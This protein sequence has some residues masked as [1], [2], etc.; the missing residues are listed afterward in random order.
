MIVDKIET[1]LRGELASPPDE[2]LDTAARF[3]RASL[4]RNLTSQPAD[5][6]RHLSASSP[7]Y[8]AKRILYGLRGAEK[9]EQNPRSRLAFTMGDMVEQ[10]GVLLTRLAGIDVLSPAA[11]GTQE[12]GEIKAAGQAVKWHADMVIR[13]GSGAEIPVDFKSM[14]EYGFGE[15]QS[16]CVDPQHKWHAEERWG[17]VSQLMVYMRAKDAPYGLFVGVNKN[18]GH[19]AEMQVP[20]DPRWWKEYEDRIRFV[21]AHQAAGSLPARPPW[22]TTETKPGD[23]LRADGS[24]GAVEEVRH[25]RCNYCPFVGTCYEGFSLVP[26][27]AK[28]AWRKAVSA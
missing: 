26:L 6:R 1:Y 16:A 23:N 19:L 5:D 2:A 9:V 11:D 4:S 14:A 18:T 3:F 13:D 20:W 7:L 21:M 10:M 28:P 15:F 17:Y 8:C 22:A 12:G 24:K 25:W 27:K